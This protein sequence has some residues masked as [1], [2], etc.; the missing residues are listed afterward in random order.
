MCV[1]VFLFVFKDREVHH[2]L[3]STSVVPF[4]LHQPT[5]ALATSLTQAYL[6]H[7]IV[8][9]HLQPPLEGQ[10]KETPSEASHTIGRV[11]HHHL[12]STSVVPFHLH[13][14]A[15]TWVTSLTQ[16]SHTP[17]CW[18]ISTCRLKAKDRDNK[19]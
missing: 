11:V 13:Q 17:L 2:H 18:A 6:T 19:A 8:L 16:V 10:G 9:G 12:P 5:S 15:S 1:S 14:P 3:P 4:H 7:F